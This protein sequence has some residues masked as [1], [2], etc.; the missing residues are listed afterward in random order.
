MQISQRADSGLA[1][2]SGSLVEEMGLHLY[3]CAHMTHWFMC[4][5]SS[6]ASSSCPKMRNQGMVNSEWNDAPVCECRDSLQIPC[7][8]VTHVLL[9]WQLTAPPPS[10]CT[11][12]CSLLFLLLTAPPPLPPPSPPPPHSHC[13]SS[14]SLHLILLTAPL[15]PAHCSSFFSLLLPLLAAPTGV[16]SINEQRLLSHILQFSA[17]FHRP[18]LHLSPTPSLFSWCFFIGL[19]RERLYH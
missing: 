3:N 6:T 9:G 10:H 5:C 4:S 15:P 2:Y 1:L 11:S 19:C 17:S 13:T 7:W 18:A 14:C 12:S 8:S 16:P